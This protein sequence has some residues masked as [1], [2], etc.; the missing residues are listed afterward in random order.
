MAAVMLY[1]NQGAT[2]AMELIRTALINCEV[3]LFKNDVLPTPSM[4]EADLEEADFSGY[5]A[6]VVAA[7]LGAY[8]DPGGG[9]SAQLPTVQFE[10][11]GGAVDNIIYGFW[12]QSAAPADKTWVIARFQDPIPMSQLGHAIP[13]DI[14]VNFAN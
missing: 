2:A 10:H 4:V 3:K 5:A 9:A 14:K 13:L 11:S 8:L 6:E 7:L 1:S 12:V